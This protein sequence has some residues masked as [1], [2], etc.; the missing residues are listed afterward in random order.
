MYLHEF[1]SKS[2][3][4]RYTPEASTYLFLS[5]FIYSKNCLFCGMPLYTN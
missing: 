3:V 2:E 5:K 4:I 1:D